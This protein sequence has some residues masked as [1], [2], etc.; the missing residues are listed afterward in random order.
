[1]SN[2]AGLYYGAVGAGL[3]SSY[4]ASR[5]LPRTPAKSPQ[6]ATSAPSTGRRRRRSDPQVENRRV[7]RRVFRPSMGGGGCLTYRR[8]RSGKRLTK[9][10]KRVRVVNAGLCNN[11]FRLSGLY[12]GAQVIGPADGNQVTCVGSLVQSSGS[13]RLVS[14]VNADPQNPFVVAP[15]FA[16][17]IT[18]VPNT[19]TNKLTYPITALK[20][21]FASKEK[22]ANFRWTYPGGSFPV[23]TSSFFPEQLAYKPIDGARG[24]LDWLSAKFMFY[25]PYYVPTR[26]H[27]AL[28]RF[29]ENSVT[30]GGEYG[31][32]QDYVS[33]PTAIAFWESFAKKDMVAPIEPGNSHILKKYM[34]VLWKDSF[35]LDCKTTVEN[36]ITHYKQ[37]DLFK[38]LN[39]KCVYDWL[40]KGVMDLTNATGDGNQAGS[41]WIQN[42]TGI[43][44]GV[45]VDGVTQT[46][47][48]H[49]STTVQTQYRTFLMVHAETA[50]SSLSS[51]FNA[52]VHPSFDMVLRKK[53]VTI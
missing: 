53:H 19:N 44:G 33:D 12:K 25:A 8:K 22:G 18:S 2:L 17:D 34:K 51:N 50:T 41:N 35:L 52:Y 28:V 26:I 4:L 21:S 3:V 11:V 36:E 45:G 14:G 43:P 7:R 24:Y 5:G 30:P 38:R 23:S 10:Q 20:L 1:M 13:Y 31:N 6:K 39:M 37:Y 40:D 9:S 46:T 15:V 49:F 32:N 27:V 47:V 48:N 16:F 29:K 42:G